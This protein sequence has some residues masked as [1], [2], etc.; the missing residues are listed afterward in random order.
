MSKLPDTVTIEMTAKHWKKRKAIGFF[1]MLISAA[2]ALTCMETVKSGIGI[3]SLVALLFLP[4]I[5]YL[6]VNVMIWWHHS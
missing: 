3:L 2:I 6:Y 5:Y 1:A 4:V